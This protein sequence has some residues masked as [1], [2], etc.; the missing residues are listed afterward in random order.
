MKTWLQNGGN[1][2]ARDQLIVEEGSSAIGNTTLMY[3]AG[4]NYNPEVIK[5]LL[6]AGANIND[7][8]SIGW[9]AL[10]Y[11]GLA[12]VN[13]EIIQL[14]VAQGADVNVKSTNGST[15]LHVSSWENSN[16][17]ITQALI[18]AGANVNAAD[19]FGNT[20]LITAAMRNSP[21]IILLLLESGAD[22]T[23][24]DYKGKKAIDY[25]AENEKLINTDAFWRLNDASF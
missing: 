10:Y 11:A 14:L 5:L 18:M 21:E 9:T 2:N 6:D 4:N 16:P 19:N 22:A 12:N 24:S 13:V 3:A 7:R 8:S 20:P 1:V 25:A 23:I 17:L 15:A